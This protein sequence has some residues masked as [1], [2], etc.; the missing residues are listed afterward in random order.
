MLLWQVDSQSFAS[1]SD[2]YPELCSEGAYPNT[3]SQSTNSGSP[4]RNVSKAFYSTAELQEVVAF[5]KSR[6][7][8]LMP[9]WDMPGHSSMSMGMPEVATRCVSDNQLCMYV[10]SS[11]NLDIII[12]IIIIQFQFALH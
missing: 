10:P 9:E 5:A 12:V 8:R 6:G 4:S 3:Y 1:C 2:S 11:T 7:V